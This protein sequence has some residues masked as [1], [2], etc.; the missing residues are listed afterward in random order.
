MNHKVVEVE[1]RGRGSVV[2]C[3]NGTSFEGERV[4]VAVPIGPLKSGSIKF[5]PELPSKKAEAIKNI[6]FGNV[7]KILIV[8]KNKNIGHKE[9]Y[10]GV[11]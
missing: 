2:K 6:N 4:V 9:H 10:I 5:K 7:C 1:N 8:L 3:S 11:I